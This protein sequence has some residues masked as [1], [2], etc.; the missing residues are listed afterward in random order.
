MQ[1]I[2]HVKTVLRG[3][4]ARV[5]EQAF[6]ATDRAS[7]AVLRPTTNK[8]RYGGGQASCGG[9]GGEKTAAS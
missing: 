6:A 4:C 1:C 9:G 5:E 8:E 3:A 7:R 2:G